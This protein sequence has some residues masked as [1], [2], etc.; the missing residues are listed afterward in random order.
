MPPD[1]GISSQYKVTTAAERRAG[2]HIRSSARAH[3]V[4]ERLAQL[5]AAADSPVS[6]LVLRSSAASPGGA[7]PQGEDRLLQLLQVRLPGS[8]LPASRHER[9]WRHNGATFNALSAHFRRAFGRFLVIYGYIIDGMLVFTRGGGGDGEK[10]PKAPK[11]QKPDAPKKQKEKPQKPAKPPKKS[12]KEQEKDSKKGKNKQ[13][14][15]DSDSDEDGGGG[16]GGSDSDDSD[17]DAAALMRKYGLSA[18][19]DS[20]DDLATPAQE[21]D[22]VIP[23]LG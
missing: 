10:R 6:A 2:A 19:D 4:E 3:T 11:K 21:A 12:K 15:D 20:F 8:R 17:I 13:K 23:A 9:S 22:R 14:K 5:A 18:D 1:V 7:A 16:D